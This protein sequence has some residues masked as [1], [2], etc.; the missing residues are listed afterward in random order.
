ML[1]D[2]ALLLS[3]AQKGTAEEHFGEAGVINLLHVLR[4]SLRKATGGASGAAGDAAKKLSKEKKDAQVG[5]HGVCPLLAKCQGL[6]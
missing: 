5:L 4:E 1:S 2:W 3:W 6:A